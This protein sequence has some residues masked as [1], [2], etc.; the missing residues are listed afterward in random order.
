VLVTASACGCYKSTAVVASTW[1]AHSPLMVISETVQF[2]HFNHSHFVSN[3]FAP[4]FL[5]S[6]LGALS[7]EIKESVD[8]IFSDT[9][10]MAKTS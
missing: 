6:F 8:E 10:I 2:S 5:H 9:K 1:F 7:C 4:F 3:P